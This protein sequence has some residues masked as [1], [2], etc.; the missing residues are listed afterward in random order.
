MTI[1]RV[2]AYPAPFAGKVNGIGCILFLHREP[3]HTPEHIIDNCSVAVL[4]SP[5][6]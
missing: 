4:N 5:M 3:Q 6:D 1:L 2:D